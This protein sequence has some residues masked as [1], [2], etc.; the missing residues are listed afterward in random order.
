MNKIVVI[1][2]GGVVQEVLGPVGTV[3]EVLDYDDAEE[4][5]TV[6]QI[7]KKLKDFKKTLKSV[8]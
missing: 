7:D 3:V 2:S 6:S 4:E 1:V 5:K 8:Y